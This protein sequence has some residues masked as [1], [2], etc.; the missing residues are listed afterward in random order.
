MDSGNLVPGSAAI[1]TI[2]AT[3]LEAKVES[4]TLQ[5]NTAATAGELEVAGKVESLI[6]ATTPWTFLDVCPTP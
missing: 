4:Y 6:M 1:S 2:L 3:K 5:V